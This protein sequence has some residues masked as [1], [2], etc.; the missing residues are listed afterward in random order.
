MWVPIDGGV[1]MWGCWGWDESV[2]SWSLRKGL[3][4]ILF[5]V[6]EWSFCRDWVVPTE[7]VVRP[8]SAQTGAVGTGLA[9]L[10]VSL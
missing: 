2:M 1:S 7:E 3:V 8:V 6:E 4:P 9:P 10:G 5:N